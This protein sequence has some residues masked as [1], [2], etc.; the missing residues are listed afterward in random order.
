MVLYP[1]VADFQKM[2]WSWVPQYFQAPEK[3]V[4]VTKF[5]RDYLGALEST[6]YVFRD[7]QQNKLT[8]EVNTQN[9]QIRICDIIMLK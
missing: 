4:H 1:N 9:A 5:V 6:T 7:S 2:K 8:Y 3:F